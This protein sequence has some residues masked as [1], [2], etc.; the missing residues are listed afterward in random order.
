MEL[1][2]MIVIKFLTTERI[3]AHQILAKSEAHFGGMA[4]LYELFGSGKGRSA[5][6]GKISM[7][8]IAPDGRPSILLTPPFWASLEN[9]D[10][11]QGDPLGTCSRCRTGRS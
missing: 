3:D 10:L 6:D 2:Q 11:N 8:S 5:E 1:E 7:T 9:P 4:Y